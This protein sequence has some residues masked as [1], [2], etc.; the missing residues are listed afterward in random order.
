MVVEYRYYLIGDTFYSALNSSL[1]YYAFW[2][3]FKIWF[4]LCCQSYWDILILQR[5]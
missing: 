2:L 4:S 3:C 5:K 1:K